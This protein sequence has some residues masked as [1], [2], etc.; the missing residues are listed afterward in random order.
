MNKYSLTR[1]SNC[2]KEI[3]GRRMRYDQTAILCIRCQARAAQDRRQIR[4]AELACRDWWGWTT[5]GARCLFELELR[6]KSRFARQ[7]EKYL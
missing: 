7:V 4:R 5:A 3:P 2:E 1:C 6:D